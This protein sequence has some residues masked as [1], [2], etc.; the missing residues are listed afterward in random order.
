MYAGFVVPTMFLTLRASILFPLNGSRPWSGGGVRVV[1]ARGE[2]AIVG[3]SKKSA[4]TFWSTPGY[5]FGK[6]MIYNHV[7]VR[8]AMGFGVKNICLLPF[9]GFEFPRSTREQMPQ[10]KVSEGTLH[11]LI[12]LPRAL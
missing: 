4:P 9:K 10:R 7:C 5:V 1:C 12:G 11:I 3:G 8:C 6:L 2:D